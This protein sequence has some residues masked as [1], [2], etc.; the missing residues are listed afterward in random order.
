MRSTCWVNN[1][2]PTLELK[3]KI[4]NKK[5]VHGG[6]FLKAGCW[7][8]IS[9]ILEGK[10]YPFGIRNG[11]RMRTWRVITN[12]GLRV[13]RWLFLGQFTIGFTTCSTDSE[14]RR[15]SRSNQPSSELGE[16]DVHP[17][18]HTM[19]FTD[20]T[21]RNVRMFANEE[22]RFFGFKFQNKRGRDC[23]TKRLRNTNKL[24]SEC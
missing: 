6:F 20:W 10:V 11:L 7:Q 22:R 23:V 2:D 18:Y 9:E 8:W 17:N 13:N 19:K 21:K 16:A 12:H 1:V 5:S 24:T 15:T 3:A 14:S 4:V